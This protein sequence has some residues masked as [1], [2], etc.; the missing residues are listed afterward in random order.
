MGDLRAA[1]ANDDGDTRKLT[2]ALLRSLSFAKVQFI[3]YLALDV[4]NNVRCKVVP[5]SYLRRHPRRFLEGVTFA[6]VCLGGL[7]S[8]ADQIQAE[9]GLTAAGSIRVLPD[10]ET[11]RILPYASDSAIVLGSLIKVGE[12]SDQNLGKLSDLCCR[13]LLQRVEKRARSEHNMIF[14]VGAELEFILFDKTTKC[15]CERSTFADTNILNQ[16]QMFIS[17]LYAQLQQQEILVELLHAESA[18]GQMELVFEHLPDPCM[19]ADHILL[20]RENIKGLANH[21]GLKAIF[22]PKVISEQAGNGLHIH[23]AFIDATSGDSRFSSKV[24]H[25]MMPMSP[26][27]QSFVEGILQHLGALQGITMPTTNSFQRVGRGCWTGSQA[28]WG[29]DDKE[30]PLRVIQDG[31]NSRV[32]Y[33]LCDAL[34]NLYLSMACILTAGMDGIRQA[35]RLR[36]QNDT[37]DSL[38][39]PTTI[40][41]S[42]DLLEEDELMKQL[43]PTSMMKCHLAA[44]RAEARQASEFASLAAEVRYELEKS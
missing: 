31:V 11:L 24:D 7:T 40:T 2:I 44:R 13:S 22:L 9:S 6:E 37:C 8:Y 42:L 38:E 3:R 27:G 32:E 21:H 26:E 28:I 43:L 23:I 19:L 25:D 35:A 34:A 39:L 1:M 10:L 41:E 20:A 15:P 5:V 36:P 33:K 12:S 17:D 14:T 30:A 4:G 16:Q 18:A 29:L